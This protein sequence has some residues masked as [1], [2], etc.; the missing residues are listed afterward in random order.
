MPG[1]SAGP[2]FRIL[3]VE[4]DFINAFVLQKYLQKLFQVVH[5]RSGQEA[6]G[7]YQAEP[8]D[9]VLMDINLG[10]EELDGTETMKRIRQLPLPQPRAIFAVTAYVGEEYRQML[11]AEGFD[12]YFAKPI[13][14]EKILAAVQSACAV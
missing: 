9:V 14:K 13:E 10:D 6:L 11:L 7:L 2:T 8:F 5:A 1:D 12:D 3:L 4:D